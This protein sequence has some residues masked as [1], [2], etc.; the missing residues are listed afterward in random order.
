MNY[1]VIFAIVD[2]Y[3]TM[4][5]DKTGKNVDWKGTRL[6]CQEMRMSNGKTVGA[7]SCII[8]ANNDIGKLP[9]GIPVVIF[10]DRNGKAAKVE[11]I[12]K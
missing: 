12:K 10:F 7:N 3:G 1:Y 4:K 8:K 5:D 2:D 6:L 11:E 9:T